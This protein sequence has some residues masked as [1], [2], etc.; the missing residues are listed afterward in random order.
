MAGKDENQKSAKYETN[1]FDNPNDSL[2]LHYSDQPG[3]TLVTQPLNREKYSTWSLAML[4]AL[5]IKNKEGF[6]NGSIKQPCRYNNLVKAWLSNS[7]SQDIAA[8]VIYYEDA[9]EIWSDLKDRFSR[10]NSVHLLHVEEAIYNCQQD[11]MTIATYYTKLKGL[12]D[13]R[14]ALYSFPQCSCSAMKDVL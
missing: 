2:Y 1:K 5:N 14:D 8:S 3:L 9:S 6:V 12:W 13:E 7:I 4:M 11:N 10:T